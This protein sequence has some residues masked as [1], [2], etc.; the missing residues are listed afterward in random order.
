MG[1]AY[2]DVLWLFTVLRVDGAALAAMTPQTLSQACRSMACVHAR[3]DVRWPRCAA[4]EIPDERLRRDFFRRV[5]D[6]KMT[7][8]ADANGSPR[9]PSSRHRQRTADQ[10]SPRRS[11]SPTPPPPPLPATA[12]A[13]SPPHGPTAAVTL[14]A[15]PPPLHLQSTGP[16][17]V[18]TLPSQAARSA[19][20]LHKQRSD[21]ALTSSKCFFH[22]T[23]CARAQLTPPR[24]GRH[25]R[26]RH[27]PV[28]ADDDVAARGETRGRRADNDRWAH[29][30]CTRCGAGALPAPPHSEVGVR[31]GTPTAALG[32]RIARGA[33]Q[34][35]A[36]ARRARVP[37][38]S[39]MRLCAADPTL[40]PRAATRRARSAARP[41]VP[42]RGRI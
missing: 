9:S 7:D 36:P 42:R 40:A 2:N 28:A 25:S 18:Q 4:Q 12:S 14:P 35:S 5:L 39:L 13:Q 20:P 32:R 33:G 30:R 8:W 29:C 15:R 38:C 22:T 3:D 24:R 1:P 6:Q 21:S 17:E 37:A 16:A 26:Q 41:C 27:P 19:R 23:I 34:G 11:E 31:D 10:T